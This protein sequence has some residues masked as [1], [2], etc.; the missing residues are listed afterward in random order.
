MLQ[1]KKVKE[2]RRASHVSLNMQSGSS[3]SIEMKKVPNKKVN[4]QTCFFRFATVLSTCLS[5]RLLTEKT[6]EGKGKQMC[7]KRE[8]TKREKDTTDEQMYEQ[9]DIKRDRMHVKSDKLKS[10]FFDTQ[11]KLLFKKMKKVKVRNRVQEE[12]DQENKRSNIKGNEKKV[13]GKRDE[14]K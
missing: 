5:E 4:R 6:K 8:K 13:K 1:K 11:G 14:Q 10:F 3:Q 7:E 2:K 9:K 12:G